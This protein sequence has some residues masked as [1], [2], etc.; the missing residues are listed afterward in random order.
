MDNKELFISLAAQQL[1]S[2]SQSAVVTLGAD[3]AVTFTLRQALAATGVAQPTAPAVV[4]SDAPAVE[5]QEEIER[6]V[7][8]PQDLPDLVLAPVTEAPAP[9]EPAEAEV[10]L[11]GVTVTGD[12]SEDEVAEALRQFDENLPT[13][14][15][16][17][18]W[19][20]ADDEDGD[21][22]DDDDEDDY[23][24]DEGDRN[25]RSGAF[26]E[27]PTENGVVTI[28]DV[29]DFERANRAAEE[30]GVEEGEPQIIITYRRVDGQEFTAE[31]LNKVINH[32]LSKQGLE[33]LGARVS[34]SVE[35]SAD[36]ASYD[37]T[38]LVADGTVSVAALRASCVQY[39]GQM[40][41]PGVGVIEAS[42]KPVTLPAVA[43]EGEEQE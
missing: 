22:W 16:P 17:D 29:T 24:Y 39:R 7:V 27:I 33:R 21:D 18:N 43:A 38:W 28:G 10:D 20:D 8:A 4:T 35:Q 5:A 37:T 23:D 3:H 30:Q 36:K 15:A 26:A 25:P 2:L 13:P 40:P 31:D 11:R 42:A 34:L 41:F 19:D 1:A 9:V 32:P 14:V 6:P 12:V